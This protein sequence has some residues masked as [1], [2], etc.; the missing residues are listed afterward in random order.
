[1]VAEIQNNLSIITD[2][3]KKMQVKG[4]YV[5]GSAVRGDFAKTS[6]IDFLVSYE[7][8]QS[9]MPPK[10]F[11]YFE[12]WFAL[13]DITGRKVDLVVEHSIRNE[14]FRK[15]IEKEKILLYAA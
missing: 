14:Y 4:L 13:E 6:D 1:M 2:A 15:Q 11:D 8:D 10:E 5:F 3:C 7:I 12:L 9:G